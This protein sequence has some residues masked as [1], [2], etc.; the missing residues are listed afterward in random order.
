[1]ILSSS[2]LALLERHLDPAIRT[3]ASLGSHE[4]LLP[5]VQGLAHSTWRRPGSVPEPRERN[6][7]TAGR[8]LG[9]GRSTATVAVWTPGKL[10]DPSPGAHPPGGGAGSRLITSAI[11]AQAKRLSQEHWSHTVS[12]APIGLDVAQAFVNSEDRTRGA[13]EMANAEAL[14]DWLTKWGLAPREIELSTLDQVKT[15][16]LRTELRALIAAQHFKRGTSPRTDLNRLLATIGFRA[17]AEPEGLLR[18]EPSSEGLDGALAKLL[19]IAVQAQGDG[20]WR[21]LK[22]CAHKDCGRVFYDRSANRSGRWCSMRTCGNK[23][24]G[25]AFRRRYRRPRLSR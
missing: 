8:L 15:H 1:M 14:S 3:L 20:T 16:Q 21:R 19:L 4:R 24:K 5:E 13:D 12:M 18:F 17:F 22:V 25:Q 7:R 9:E 11:M 2:E 10:L 23:S 6:G